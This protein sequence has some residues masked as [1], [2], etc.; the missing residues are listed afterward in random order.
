MVGFRGLM[1][2]PPGAGKGTQGEILADRLGI[3]HLATGDLLRHHVA[4]GT[5]I[6]R[7][8]KSHMDAGGLV[9]DQLVVDMVLDRLEKNGDDG[10]LLDGF[11]RTLAQAT[12]AFESAVAINRTFH[13]VLMLEVDEDELV[14]RLVERGRNQG[15]SDDHEDVIAERLRVY[16]E[17]TKP[18][19]EF[20]ED[21]RI[22]HRINGMGT[23]DEVAERIKFV[24]DSVY[25]DALHV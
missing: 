24:V 22:L 12:Q 17:N 25:P 13:A 11:P 4:E 19:I 10:F 21:R 18:L 23:V 5:D 1:L 6:G 9:P 2:A 8:A 7:E 14:R 3:V 15:R 20:Y 16:D